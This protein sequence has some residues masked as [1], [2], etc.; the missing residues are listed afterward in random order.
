[1][2]FTSEFGILFLGIFVGSILGI[3][4]AK[5]GGNLKAAL[6]VVGA[7]L[8]GGP[9]LFIEGVAA[10]RWAYPVGLVLGLL[11][12]RLWFAREAII[13]KRVAKS[14]RVFAWLD[15][16]AIVIVTLAA[17]IWTAIPE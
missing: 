2:T 13:D 1:M 8:G 4:L 15:I 16:V 10:A 12:L 5:A 11:V 3:G 7:A 14:K 9:I 6:A 17:V